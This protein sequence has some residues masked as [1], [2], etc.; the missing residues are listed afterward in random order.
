MNVDI[1]ETTY[2][3]S[4]DHPLFFSIFK[5]MKLSFIALLII[6][7]FVYIIIFFVVGNAKRNP[8]DSSFN[9]I[10]ILLEIFLWSL[11]LYVIYINLKYTNDKNYNFQAEVSNLFN[12]KLADLSVNAERN[13]YLNGRNGEYSEEKKEKKEKKECKKCKDDDDNS[14]KEVFHIANNKYN[15]REAKN[16]CE[17]YNSELASYD[18][19]EDAYNNGANWCSYG[20]SEDQL[21]LFPTQKEKYN[22]L[23][24]IPGHEHDCGR[25]GIN[26]GYFPNKRIKFG[27]NCYGKK[28]KPKHKDKHYMHSVNHTPTIDKLIE[29]KKKKNIYK[30]YIVAPFN[31]DVWSQKK[32]N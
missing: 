1:D 19:I 22:E 27:V 30:N 8:D 31:N 14:K 18:Q 11:L 12:T 23:K 3:P 6:I 16:I 26:G 10:V 17:K 15:Y 21:A 29:N 2:I 25:P 5:N 7:I 28:P 13:H 20:W 4:T 9:V 32:S 24:E